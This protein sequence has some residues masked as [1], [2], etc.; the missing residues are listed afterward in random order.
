MRI[1]PVDEDMM[2]KL[3]HAVTQT[4]YTTEHISARR[5]TNNQSLMYLHRS[6]R[7]SALFALFHKAECM[8]TES[9]V[10][11]GPTSC[12][13][14]ISM[15]CQDIIPVF[16]TGSRVRQSGD[17]RKFERFNWDRQICR[18]LHE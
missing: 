17:R 13:R 1:P 9:L 2:P 14:L 6:Y 3:P 7:R 4:A 18:F 8:F 12:E 5:K 16:R 15:C 11:H 10:L